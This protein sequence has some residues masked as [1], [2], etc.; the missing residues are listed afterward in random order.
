MP[1]A[2]SPSLWAD[3]GTSTSRATNWGTPTYDPTLPTVYNIKEEYLNAYIAEAYGISPD[4]LT[5]ISQSGVGLIQQVDLNDLPAELSRRE[6]Q[7]LQREISQTAI[8]PQEFANDIKSGNTFGGAISISNAILL[9]NGLDQLFEV[10]L[11]SLEEQAFVTKQINPFAV[12]YSAF[13]NRELDPTKNDLAAPFAPID[14]RSERQTQPNPHNNPGQRNGALV[15][16]DETITGYEAEVFWTLN[17]NLQFIFAYSHTEREALDDFK[18]SDYESITGTEINGF[19]APFGE[20]YREYGWANAGYQL[21]WVDYDVYAPLRDAADGPVTLDDLGGA[22]VE[23]VPTEQVDETIPV[24]E[25][26]SK[27][28]N[29]LIPLFVDKNGAIVDRNNLPRPSD[30]Q[31][32][33]D[34]VSLNFN[35]EDEFTARFRYKFTESKLD[36]LA[37]TGGFKYI[38]PS[39]TSVLF[40]SLSPLNELTQT[41]E[42]SERLVFDLGASY[43]WT[44]DNIRFQLRLNVYNLFNDTYDVTTTTLSTPN[45]ITGKQ[46]TRRTESFYTPT[47]WRIGLSASF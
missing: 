34:G 22:V 9:A 17:D 8:I 32:S 12:I 25:I 4:K 5:F 40:R 10:Q 31:S 6:K 2:P 11:Y 39:K 13:M 14:Y 46:V 24:S 37:I 7:L 20:V 29:G 26:A 18:Y 28:A 41:P 42:V 33:I 21:A 3:A 44:W 43:G 15:V 1:I 35:P 23:L 45:P 19:I 47:A 27:N 16:F 36:G 30:Y 38:G